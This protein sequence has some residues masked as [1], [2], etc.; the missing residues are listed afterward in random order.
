MERTKNK[1]IRINNNRKLIYLFMF[2]AMSVM[3]LSI[4]FAPNNGNNVLVTAKKNTDILFLK[5][6]FILKDKKGSI[7]ISDDKKPCHCPHYFR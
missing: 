1:M 6:K 5:G 3:V 2:V 7:V 4:T